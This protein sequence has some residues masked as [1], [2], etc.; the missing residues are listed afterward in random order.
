MR[1]VRETIGNTTIFIQALDEDLAIV[2]ERQ[3]GPAI[4]NTGIEDTL[5]EVYSKAK[6]IIKDIAEDIGTELKNLPITA[7][8]K[9]VE[10]EF[11]MSLSAQAGIWILTGGEEHTFM[12]KLIWEL[13]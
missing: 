12:I 6:T 3:T 5:K 4:I 11:N 7:R 10:M 8:P 1:V 2:N 13:G 9:Q